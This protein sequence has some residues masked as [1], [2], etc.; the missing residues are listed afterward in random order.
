[1]VSGAGATGLYTFT[2]LEFHTLLTVIGSPF[3]LPFKHLG[4]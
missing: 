4:L 1:V 2:P 3:Y